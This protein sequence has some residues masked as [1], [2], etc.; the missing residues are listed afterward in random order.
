MV[1]SQKQQIPLLVLAVSK[2][3]EVVIQRVVLGKEM[4][5]KRLGDCSPQ[6]GPEKHREKGSG[7]RLSGE[8]EPVWRHRSPPTL[9][10]GQE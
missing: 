6:L 4:G 5:W 9:A 1:K 2:M 10:H 7:H 3:G 8:S